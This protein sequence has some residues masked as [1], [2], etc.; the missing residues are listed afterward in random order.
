MLFAIYCLDKEDSES[1]RL[2]NRAAHLAHLSQH[3]VRF[4][5]PLLSDDGTGMVGS[6]IIAEFEDATAARA[7]A[8]ADP[9]QNAGLFQRVEIRPYRLAIGGAA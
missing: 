2:E 3:D 7:F 4:A 6:L 9:Y 5:G 8:D 1:V